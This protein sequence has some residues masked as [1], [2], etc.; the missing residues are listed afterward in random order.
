MTTTAYL[1]AI[2]YDDTARADE[3][4]DELIQL[5]WGPG[6]AGRYRL[7]EDI[8]VVVRHPNG[9][10]TLD[11]QPFPGFANIAAW[12]TVG[13][14]AGLVLAALLP[15]A[16]IGALLGSAGTAAASR[17]GISE[18]F[19]REVQEMMKPATSALF[20]LVDQLDMEVVLHQIR[21]LGGTVLKTNVDRERA[22]L[23]QS[24][25]AATAGQEATNFESTKPEELTAFLGK[26]FIYTYDNGWQYE[27]YIKNDRTIDYRI[28]SG[29]V[30]GRWVRN[31]QAHIV[32]LADDIVKI[33]WDEPTGTTV[34]A[35]FML[36]S[37]KVHGAI[38]FPRWIAEEPKKTVC[39]QND[40]LDKMTAYR[41]AGPTYPKLVIDEF[42][43]ITFMEDSGLNNE[44]VI[45]CPPDQLPTGYAERHN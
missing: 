28:H 35:A 36:T 44:E 11:R 40:F 20:L 37:R 21:G 23:I 38:F 30:G 18:T 15:G 3:V 22:K 41:D 24:A 12:T 7:L 8:A 10:F 32:R 45:S 34:S 13:S 25:L 42:A 4:R 16:A 27:L 17:T 2:G 14:L 6:Q 5:A 19:I 31:Q 29:M 43:T 9:S 26:H 33:S 1:W 39:Y